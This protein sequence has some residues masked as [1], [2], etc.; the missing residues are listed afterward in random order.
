FRLVGLP[1]TDPIQ[2]F[3]WLWA[4]TV[5]WRSDQPWREHLRFARD[6]V[7]VVVLLEVYNL[8]RGFADNGATPHVLELVHADRAMFGWLTGGPVP[9][10]W[11]QQHLYDPAV[12]HWWD[13]L[14]SWVYFSHFVAGLGVAVVLWLR[15]RTRWAA[16]MRR[17]FVLSAAG[18]VTYFVYPA[19]PPWWAAQY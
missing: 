8:S 14:A 19:A 15:D 4:A 9:T 18:L 7:P 5:A 11:L 13:V 6:W 16:F 1:G 10:V 12:I 2:A 3:V 17:W